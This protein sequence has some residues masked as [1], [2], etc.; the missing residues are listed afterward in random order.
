MRESESSGTGLDS[1]ISNIRKRFCFSFS[2]GEDEPIFKDNIKAHN[3]LSWSVPQ[4]SPDQGRSEYRK[5]FIF[6]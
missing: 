2:Q 1:R 4:N 3:W 6:S 5:R